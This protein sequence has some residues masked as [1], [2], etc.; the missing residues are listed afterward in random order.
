M[1]EHKDDPAGEMRALIA[2]WERAPDPDALWVLRLL[3]EAL[4]EMERKQERQEGHSMRKP[5]ITEGTT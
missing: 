5:G 2:R 3:R 1:D 4:E